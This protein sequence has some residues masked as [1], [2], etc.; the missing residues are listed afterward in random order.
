[1]VEYWGMGLVSLHSGTDAG[2]NNNNVVTGIFFR[3]VKYWNCLE[4]LR[5]LE[6]EYDVAYTT[7]V[8]LQ[9]KGLG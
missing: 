2:N 1:M 8:V 4:M 3:S 6:T 7:G 9:R 5:K